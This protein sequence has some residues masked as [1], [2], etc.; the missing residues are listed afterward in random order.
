M[1]Q[2]KMYTDHSMYLMEVG[3]K[4]KIQARGWTVP[5]SMSNSLITM[6]MFQL[7][8]KEW[9][10]VTSNSENL[11]LESGGYN[12]LTL[13]SNNHVEKGIS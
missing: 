10:G 5:D 7:G 1:H 2:F 9:V 3:E 6:F 12:S 8:S 11:S 4:L 13:V